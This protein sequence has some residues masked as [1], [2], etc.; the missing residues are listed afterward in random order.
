[1]KYLVRSG[2]LTGFPELV[3]RYGQ[4]PLDLLDEV[5]IP[6]AALHNPELYLSYP[7]VGR[8]LTLAA[9]RCKA[10]DFGARLGS[11]QG[12]EVVGALGT[13]LCLQTRVGDALALIRRHV[14]FHAR[15]VVIDVHTDGR[16]IAVQMQLA[17]GD[18]I[19]SAQL[20]ALS[21]A[22]LARSIAQLHGSAMRP[23]QVEL[24]MPPPADLRGWRSAYGCMP[25]FAAPADRI[26]YPAELMSLPVRITHSLRQRL[27][28]QWR[29]QLPRS[30]AAPALTE[31]VERAIVAL[32]PTGDCS[33]EGVAQLVDL[34]PRVLQLRLQREAISFGGLLRRTR[35]RLAREHLA[36][37]DMNLT[38]LA[39]NLGFG[40]LAVF[41]RAFRVWTGVSP[42]A[43][44]RAQR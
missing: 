31:Q 40:D 33:L 9:Q 30:N 43:W 22:L 14:D 17:F 37:S 10:A 41:S 19:D 42:R 38:T 29:G 25:R 1:M 7:M 5:G 44:R 36:R 12:L 8:L 35:E 21:M 20:M 11:R 18:E 4:R 15:G 6:A 16:R 3:E 26:A 34:H 32:L 23:L 39:M 2:S 27:N 24:S 28:A 13:L